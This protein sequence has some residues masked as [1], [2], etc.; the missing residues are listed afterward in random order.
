MGN[1]FSGPEEP[2]RQRVQGFIDGATNTH[3]TGSGAARVSGAA[4]ASILDSVD[5]GDMF[6]GWTGG[7]RSNKQKKR[8]QTRRRRY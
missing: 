1:W 6:S 3:G 8:K 2:H 4:G 5:I 7:S